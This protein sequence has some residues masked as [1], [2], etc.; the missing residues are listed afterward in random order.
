MSAP[1]VMLYDGLCPICSREVRW[2]RRKA[3]RRHA[4]LAFRDI[5]A[6]DF[7]PG[8]FGLTH[9]DVRRRIHAITPEGNVIEG[10]EVFRRVY[11]EL[12]LGWLAA[13]TAWPV[14]RHLADAGYALFAR[15]RPR[16]SRH[17]PCDEACARD[18]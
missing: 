12:G 3:R 7:D 14:L 10:L 9:A 2:I 11:R 17:D 6:P 8:K 15:I 5:T 1:L 16:F 13:W 4:D 18:A